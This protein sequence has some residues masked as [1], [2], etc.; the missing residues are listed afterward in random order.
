MNLSRFFEHWSITE[1]PFRGEEARHDPVFHRLSAPGRR[2]AASENSHGG[3]TPSPSSGAPVHTT[4]SDFEKIVGEFDQPSTSIVFGEKGSG[5]T[6]I[7]MQ[8]QER[9]NRHNAINPER[10]CLLIPYDDLNPI[11]DRFAER[12]GGT[13]AAGARTSSGAA[14]KVDLSKVFAKFRL[15]DHIDAILSILLPRMIDTLLGER[16]DVE[17]LPLGNEPRRAARRMDVTLRRDLLL[18]QSLYDR[19][20]RAAARTRKL[21]RVLRLPLPRNLLI[22]RALVFTGWILPVAAVV[23]GFFYAPENVRGG[24]FVQILCGVLIAAYLGVILKRFV[25]DRLSLRR[26]G[27]RIARQIRISGRDGAS[28]ADALTTL[29]PDLRNP[30]ALPTTDSDEQRYALLSRLREALRGFG[31]ESAILVIDRIDEPTLVSGDPD[32][33][34]QII[35][36]LMNNKFLQQERFGIKMLLPIE[37]RHALFRESA[38]FFQEARL[39]KQNLIERLTWTGAMLYDLC[40]A[41]LKA[42]RPPEAPPISLIDLFADDV[43]VRDLVDAL[44]QMHQPRDAFKLLYQCLTEHCSNVTEDEA[45]WRIPRLVLETVR[46]DQAER[47]RQLYRGVRPA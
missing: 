8:L 15:V 10:R 34:R 14:G 24:L 45:Q 44:D 1:N 39:D 46:K 47:V 3:G 9:V 29:D 32:R 16:G 17:P 21:R 27:G 28:Y 31:Y 20:D 5:K 42:C 33:M 6:A 18:L 38:I 13:G 25:W 22:W 41:R 19:Q 36:P 7:R 30:A 11:L 4:H 35:W 12:V 37:L 23:W 43:T 26:L 40:N 2:T